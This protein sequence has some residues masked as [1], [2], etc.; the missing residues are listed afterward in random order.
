MERQM[1][2]DIKRRT[3]KP[4]K[5]KIADG[6]Q[7]VHSDGARDRATEIA[8]IKNFNV[9]SRAAIGAHVGCLKRLFRGED[10]L[11]KRFEPRG[12]AYSWPATLSSHTLTTL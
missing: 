12:C 11:D 9:G 8:L 1:W 10:F 2:V 5:A 6:F 4:W 3:G 7:S